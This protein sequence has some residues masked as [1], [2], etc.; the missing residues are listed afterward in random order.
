MARL[1]DKELDKIKQKF[2][3]DRI[4]SWSRVNTF[5]T[6][7]FEYLLK[8]IKNIPEDRQDCIYTSTGT[9][10]HDTLD[11]YYEGEIKYEDMIEEFN[12]GWLVNRDIAG[13]KFDRNDETKDISVGNKYR[14]NLEHFFRNHTIYKHK[15][16]IEKPVVVNI[17]NNI[18]VGYIDAMF[19]DDDDNYHI[20]DF[21][22]S[23]I[24]KGATLEEH[25]GQLVLYAIG[26]SQM[27]NIPID[28]IK[29]NFNFLKYCTI[30]YEQAN[31]TVKTRD[32]ERS[33]IGESLQSNLKVWIKKLGYADQMDELL[34][35]VIDTNG[36]ECLPQEIQDKYKITDCYVYID[37]TQELIDKWITYI[38]NT[39]KDI[40]LREKDYAETKNE[41]IFWDTE[42]QVQKESYYFATLCSYSSALHKPY[43]E[44]LSMLEK[45]KSGE[46]MFNS[47][48][49]DTVET[50]TKVDNGND[51]LDLEWLNSL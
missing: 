50:T 9:L 27:K 47:V 15:L 1:T 41:K 12:D 48:G 22:S 40:E 14:E 21:K 30:Q 36:I 7:P 19:K 26:I 4:W 31:G 29:I 44:Y 49:S 20:I 28:K 46:D 5:M 8:Y 38:C 39:I 18:F 16:L 45:K 2:N 32:V 42:E 34:K 13:L 35:M 25:S 33:K 17:N 3:V 23:S 51:D 37:L 10:C 6:S 11:K 24:Y 43:A